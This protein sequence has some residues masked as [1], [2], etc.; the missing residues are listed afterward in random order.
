M[1][2]NYERICTKHV[3]INLYDG[4]FYMT[5]HALAYICDFHRSQWFHRVSVET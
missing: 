1:L 2:T 4:T 3:I 5:V